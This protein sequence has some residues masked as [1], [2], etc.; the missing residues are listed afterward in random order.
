MLLITHQYNYKK[1]IMYYYYY[2]IIYTHVHEYSIM[3]H[4]RRRETLLWYTAQPVVE[5][6]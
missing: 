5:Y 6:I 1:R 4:K 2:Y 3:R